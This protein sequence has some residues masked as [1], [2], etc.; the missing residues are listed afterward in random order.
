MRNNTSVIYAEILTDV[1]ITKNN[2]KLKELRVKFIKNMQMTS[3][4]FVYNKT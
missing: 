4:T 3:S 2:Q 1:C